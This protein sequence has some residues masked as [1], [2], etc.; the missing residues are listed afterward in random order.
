[1]SFSFK[2][3]YFS[4]LFL[5]ILHTSLALE[6]SYWRYK[7]ILAKR[8]TTDTTLHRLRNYPFTYL[9]KYTSC[10]KFFR[11]VIGLNEIYILCN[12]LIFVWWGIFE[13][14]Y[15]SLISPACNYHYTIGKYLLKF[16]GVSFLSPPFF[17]YP[18]HTLSSPSH[19][20]PSDGTVLNIHCHHCVLK[21]YFHGNSVRMM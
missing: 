7:G 12:A 17:L 8:F 3:I 19:L 20:S 9:S 2:D 4:S 14:N 1:M 16:K 5:F 18:F 15:V 11:E 13:K 6:F 10:Q 21:I